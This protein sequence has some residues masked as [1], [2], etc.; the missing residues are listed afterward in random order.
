MMKAMDEISIEVIIPPKPVNP[1]HGKKFVFTGALEGYTR[2]EAQTIVEKFGGLI[3]GSVSS[4]T[5]YLVC[6]DQNANTSKIIDAK[7]KGITVIDELVFE[8]LLKA[9]RA[10]SDMGL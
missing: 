10:A 9:A 6:E 4:K 8:Q 3:A 2:V 7:K 1:I 5:D